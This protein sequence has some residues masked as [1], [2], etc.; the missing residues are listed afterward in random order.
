MH[1]LPRTFCLFRLIPSTCF[2]HFFAHHQE[3][4]HVQQ[5]VYF[6]A[7]YVSWLLAGSEWPRC[8]IEKTLSIV[9]TRS[10]AVC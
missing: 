4:L 6:Y 8:T 7:Y 2:E 10:T 1:C 3:V 9:R 5:L